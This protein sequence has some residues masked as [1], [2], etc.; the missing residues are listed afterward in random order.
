MLSNVR[1]TLLISATWR[2]TP[3]ESS[4]TAD[5]NFAIL[6]AELEVMVV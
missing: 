4:G 1:R 6:T 5:A 3:P 2:S